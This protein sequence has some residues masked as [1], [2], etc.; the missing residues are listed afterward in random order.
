MKGFNK[1]TVMRRG[2]RTLKLALS[3]SEQLDKGSESPW[4]HDA[5]PSGI[6]KTGDPYD[7]HQRDSLCQNTPKSKT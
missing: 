4:F 6:Y 7:G 5:T 3:L 1:V 2:I